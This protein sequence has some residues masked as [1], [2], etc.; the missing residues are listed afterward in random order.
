MRCS[1]SLDLHYEPPITSNFNTKAQHQQRKLELEATYLFVPWPEEQVVVQQG[2]SCQE[3]LG[4]FYAADLLQRYVHSDKV[5][6][7][8][9]GADSTVAACS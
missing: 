6:V 1:A 2:C 5:F 8:G 9:G 4:L 7:E 3:E